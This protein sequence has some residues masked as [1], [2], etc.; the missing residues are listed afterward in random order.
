MA[1]MPRFMRL[2]LGRSL[3]AAVL[4]TLALSLAPSAADSPGVIV[5]HGAHSGSTLTITPSPNGKRI[6]VK[7]IQA[8]VRPQGCRL[9]HHRMLA[10]CRVAGHSSMRVVMGP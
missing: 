3:T 8:R 6:V 5:I 10:V 7:G 4:A 2:P 1:T 9:K